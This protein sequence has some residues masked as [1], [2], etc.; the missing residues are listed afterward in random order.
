[1]AKK[2]INRARTR[3]TTS[4]KQTVTESRLK[5]TKKKRVPADFL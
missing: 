3:K 4:R 5:A 2:S 1:M